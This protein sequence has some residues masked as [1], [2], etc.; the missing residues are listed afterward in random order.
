MPTRAPQSL[1]ALFAQ[2]SVMLSTGKAVR[3][4]IVL[5]LLYVFARSNFVA[6][7]EF[8]VVTSE[9]GYVVDED[10]LIVETLTPFCTVDVVEAVAPWLVVVTESGKKGWI[11]TEQVHRSSMFSYIDDENADDIRQILSMVAN[12]LKNN[13]DNE[14][15]VANLTKALKTMADKF[16]KDNTGYAW[17]LT[18]KAYAQFETNDAPGAIK[19]LGEAE[20]ILRNLGE[21]KSLHAADW[22]NTKALIAKE[23]G[24]YETAIALFQEG[25]LLSSSVLGVNHADI[26][27]ITINLADAYHQK[28]D[29]DVAIRT[30]Q[31]C[32]EIGTTILPPDVAE[33]ISDCLSLAVYLSDMDRHEEAFVERLE[34]FQMVA[35]RDY[36][37]LPLA[38]T[39]QIDLATSHY[40]LGQSAV[41]RYRLKKVKEM[42]DGFDPDTEPFADDYSIPLD[43]DQAYGDMFYLLGLV[44]Q[45]VERNELALDFFEQSIEKFEAAESR[46]NIA[47]AATEAGHVAVKL[48][49]I[50]EASSFYAAAIEIYKDLEGDD[51]ESASELVTLLNGL[52]T[53]KTSVAPA[54]ENK[55]LDNGE[56]VMVAAPEA[57]LLD[58]QGKTVSLAGACSL[59]EVV[60]QSETAYKVKIGSQTLSINK[61][62]VRAG[63]T[64]PAIKLSD[65]RVQKIFSSIVDG[66]RKSRAHDYEGAVPIFEAAFQ[67]S[68]ALPAEFDQLSVFTVCQLSNAYASIGQIDRARSLL[69]SIEPT[70]NNLAEDNLGVMLDVW[71]TRANLDFSVQDNEAAERNAKK[72]LQVLKETER[73]QSCDVIA[74]E[75]ALAV[76]DM[77]NAQAETAVQRMERVMLIVEQALPSDSPLVIDTKAFFGL[78]LTFSG[79]SFEGG[80]L[81]ENAIETAR[82]R[83]E[84]TGRLAELLAY[85]GLYLNAIEKPQQAVQAFEEVISICRGNDSFHSQ[86]MMLN[87]FNE[88]AATHAS[89]QNLKL[90]GESALKGLAIADEILA[91]PFVSQAVMRSQLSRLHGIAEFALEEKGDLKA[92]EFHKLA[93]QAIEEGKDVSIVAQAD[94]IKGAD[95]KM[96]ETGTGGGD[97]SDLESPTRLGGND[98]NLWPDTERMLVLTRASFIYDKPEGQQVHPLKAG[99][100]V[101]SLESDSGWSRVVVPGND[102]YGW[103]RENDTNDLNSV[104]MQKFLQDA[105]QNN[106]GDESIGDKAAE[107][108]AAF[109]SA[110]Q[111]AGNGETDAAIEQFELALNGSREVL[112]AQNPLSAMVSAE[113]TDAYMSRQQFSRARELLEAVQP[114]TI[115]TLGSN[116]PRVA[117]NAWRLANLLNRI[118][119]IQG[120]KR[121]LELAAKIAFEAFSSKDARTHRL[122]I[123]LAT[124]LMHLGQ[125]EDA[126]KLLENVLSFVETQEQSPSFLGASANAALASI[127]FQR[128]DFDRAGELYGKSADELT[129]LGEGF[130]EARG[131]VLFQLGITSVRLGKL[132]AAK[133][134]FEAANQD[135]RV[136]GIDKPEVLAQVAYVTGLDAYLRN[137]LSAAIESIGE[138]IDQT[139]TVYGE[140]HFNTSALSSQLASI[141][142]ADGSIEEACEQFDHAR[143]SVFRYANQTLADLPVTEQTAFLQL[144]DKR[145]LERALSLALREGAGQTEIAF[146]TNWLLNSKN[147]PHALSSRSNQIRRLL[148][149]ADDLRS[150][151]DYRAARE[152]LATIPSGKV[153]AA[154][155]VFRDD[156][157]RRQ[158]EAMNEALRS[159]PAE[160]QQEITRQLS[161]WITVA[162][163]QDSMSGDEVLVEILRMRPLSFEPEQV[164]RQSNPLS[165]PVE[166]YVAWVIPASRDEAIRVV[167]LGDASEIDASVNAVLKEMSLS[168]KRIRSE[169][170]AKATQAVVTACK[171]LADTVW[172]P[173]QKSL[174]GHKKI[175]LSPDGELWRVPWIAL[176][177]GQDRLLIEEYELRQIVSGRDLVRKAETV[178]SLSAPLIMA[179]PDYDASKDTLNAATA[180]DPFGTNLS[181]ANLTYFDVGQLRAS[182]TRRATRLPGTAI[183]ARA[184]V[185]DVKNLAKQ[186][187]T[188]LLEAMANE[189][190]FRRAQRPHLVM[191]STHGFFLPNR[192]DQAKSGERLFESPASSGSGDG[193]TGLYNLKAT[194]SELQDPLMRCGLLLA[195]CNSAENATTPT[196]GILLGREIV[197]TDLRGTKLVVLSACETGLGDIVDGQGIAGLRQ[198][199]QLAGAESVVSTLWSIDDNETSR[200]MT[201]FFAQL[202]AGKNKP[203]ALRHAQ[204]TRIDALRKRNS[205]AHPLF[206][207]A[208]TLTGDK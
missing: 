91:M 99:D 194:A 170:H 23:Q 167:R 147:L 109:E 46:F 53:V 186:E 113:L 2:A 149:E 48:E 68:T 64:I 80:G 188:M 17:L 88:L 123:E 161:E 155:R 19:T 193:S 51:S 30:M 102:T 89:Q 189:A 110:M 156:E 118:G 183:E 199:F 111:L 66:R 127:A 205:A 69:D 160:V 196:D 28:G 78:V 15:V 27:V 63:K 162:E 180:R 136:S 182:L 134:L 108:M 140:D 138:A 184:V 153:D 159:L 57:P 6:A 96:A 3:L 20:Q 32:K 22:L 139:G 101:W 172:T 52:P 168:V 70:I 45:S 34:A 204:L 197:E 44:E 122:N 72:T 50:E 40:T 119:D 201:E 90:A 31:R 29:L 202:A 171:S 190:I 117:T 86:K 164:I 206:W 21:L 9:H 154:E 116:H 43:L 200:L 177:I 135:Y 95:T 14:G 58:D 84:D 132:D 41:A 133:G 16:G 7:G 130:R 142:V 85:R 79:A 195:G 37:P 60:G 187:P 8:A 26:R 67:D 158:T 181:A 13:D 38:I 81:I 148:S 166:E 152:R 62:L 42:L 11:R 18:Y 36:A 49:K 143:R 128:D 1:H 4:L 33:R 141:L 82:N 105:F 144:Q 39:T 10:D 35:A 61:Q 175:I 54:M 174:G 208:F 121:Q 185:G 114:V 120:A 150:Y 71:F 97:I 112:G 203:E 103:V 55:T 191:M 106:S 169:G 107:V 104:I 75:I 73:A 178:L 12:A 24:D 129:K 179:D 77:S 131:N 59:L 65:P 100:R 56:F 163:V 157:V 207:A 98:F 47:Y 145:D 126:T 146:T 76:L 173:I 151:S 93:V 83:K 5:S 192:T 137:D 87:A 198:A 92:A 115:A 74:L 124:I 176:P 94:R 25:M 165:R 125:T